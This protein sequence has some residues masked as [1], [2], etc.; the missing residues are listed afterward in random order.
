M[1]KQLPSNAGGNPGTCYATQA[2][3]TRTYIRE[4]TARYIGTRRV[5]MKIREP[6]DVFQ[7]VR[8]VI[9]DNSR[10][11]FVALFLD[12]GHK[13]VSYS[14]IST[15][16]ANSTQ[17]HPRELFQHAVLV[18][19]CAVVVSHNH[20][21][22]ELQPSEEDHRV[23]KHL[24]EAGRVLGIPVLDHVVFTEDSFQSVLNNGGSR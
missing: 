24:V 14:V 6:I 10:E 5:S 16:T 1:N 18:G 13:V 19:A 22:G 8:R 2:H 21:S 12:A 11:H 17:V 4:V 7:F 15:G 9:K 23:T 20:P 3:E